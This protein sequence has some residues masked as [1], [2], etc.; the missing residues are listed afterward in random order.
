M[1]TQAE[2]KERLDYN[3][4]TGILTWLIARQDYLIGERA[5]CLDSYGYRIVTIND[6]PHKAHRVIW[7]WMTGAWPE[8]EIDHINLDKDDNRWSN[9][10]EATPSQNQIN[11]LPAR[12]N[13][14]GFKEVTFI[15]A[16]PG[17]YSRDRWRAQISEKGRRFF[18]GH[19]DTPEEA[20]AAYA[21]A[22]KRRFGE[23]ARGS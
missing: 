22:A 20:H 23:F 2:V 4:E 14:T 8:C 15:K 12:Q 21:T 1:L 6:R 19:F 10:R 11:K 9:L 3:P 16:Q 17:K 5:G 13:R 7:V 18:L